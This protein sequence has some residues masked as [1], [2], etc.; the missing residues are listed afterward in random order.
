MMVMAP[1]EPE[2]ETT[3]ILTPVG[4]E[5]SALMRDVGTILAGVFPAL[6]A[7]ITKVCFGAPEDTVWVPDAPAIDDF[8]T[9]R[10]LVGSV[11]KIV[12]IIF[13]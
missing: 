2:E 1:E 6:G 8:A 11:R 10:M 4:L 12:V 5:A 9:L 3:I 7:A 13:C